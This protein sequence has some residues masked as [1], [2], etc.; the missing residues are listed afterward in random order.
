MTQHDWYI[1]D[2]AIVNGLE[3]D[4]IDLINDMMENLQ[5]I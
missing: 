5:K 3:S 4:L 2:K 1:Y